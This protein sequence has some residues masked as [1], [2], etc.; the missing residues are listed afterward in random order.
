[1]LRSQYFLFASIAVLL[2]IMGIILAQNIALNEQIQSTD[3]S[4]QKLQ[5][6][7]NNYTDTFG[8]VSF[9]QDIPTSS[10][11]LET[12]AFVAS[13]LDELT[14]VN[15]IKANEQYS[16][17]AT[18]TRPSGIADYPPLLGYVMYVQVLD[19]NDNR[20]AGSWHQDEIQVNQDISAGTYWMP[21]NVGTYTIEVFA[22]QSFAGT[23]H[24]EPLQIDVTVVD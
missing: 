9:S 22:W 17:T 11:K 19:Q 6:I 3:E 14:P 1:M 5:H 23:P 13:S 24:A 21:T 8:D 2:T 7:L 15:I 4:N 20:I 16:V 12:S 10:W 18:V